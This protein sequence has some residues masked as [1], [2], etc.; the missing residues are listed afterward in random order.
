ME[1]GALINEFLHK[2]EDYQIDDVI[3]RPSMGYPLHHTIR[4]T[5][6]QSAESVQT[7]LTDLVEFI[8][9]CAEKQGIGNIPL[10][11]IYTYQE[12]TK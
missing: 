7:H 10:C 6:P 4:F 1:C 12:F 8:E 11:F 9:E 2:N 5:T 3:V